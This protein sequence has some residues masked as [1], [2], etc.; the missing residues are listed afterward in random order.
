MRLLAFSA[1]ICARAL[2]L[3]HARGNALRPGDLERTKGPKCCHCGQGKE[4]CWQDA[5]L[6]QDAENPLKKESCTD[7]CAEYGGNLG[8]LGYTK[9]HYSCAALAG[10]GT[11]KGGATLNHL[12]LYRDGGGKMC[13]GRAEEDEGEE[14]ETET[15]PEPDETEPDE[16]KLALLVAARDGDALSERLF[17]EAKR[18]LT[19]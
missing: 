17:E 8:V 13:A 19:A 18:E 4:G 1:L 6:G 11:W 14:P 2:A 10:K 9:K 15:E 12:M 16:T 3:P 5:A 7:T